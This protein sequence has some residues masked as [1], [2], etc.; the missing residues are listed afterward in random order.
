M[1]VFML[2]PDFDGIMLRHGIR[3]VALDDA[4]MVYGDYEGTASEFAKAQQTERPHWFAVPVAESSD[5]KCLFSVEEQSRYARANGEAALLS[6]LKANGLSPGRVLPPVKSDPADAIRG[7]NNPYADNFKGTPA[8]REA[9]I[10]RL[11]NNRNGTGLATQLARAA[12]KTL[13]GQKLQLVGA[14]RK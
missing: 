3:E 5:E 4:W 1:S 6:L 7:A 11:I 8:E 10:A 9:A 14:A 13:T 12:G 2:R